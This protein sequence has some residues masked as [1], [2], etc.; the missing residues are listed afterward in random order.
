MI[1]E[2]CKAVCKST[3]ADHAQSANV[4]LGSVYSCEIKKVKGNPGLTSYRKITVLLVSAS[5]FLVG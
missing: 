2:E 5:C 1:V 4:R 3:V